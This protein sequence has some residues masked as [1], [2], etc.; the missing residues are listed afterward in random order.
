MKI[1]TSTVLELKPLLKKIP[2]TRQA[3]GQRHHLTT[4]LNLAIGAW[5]S[6][7]NRLTSIGEWARRSSPNRLKR[8]GCYFHKG[9]QRYIAPSEPTIRRVLQ[10]L[11]SSVLESI[12]ND[13]SRRLS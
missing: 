12:L 1:T 4:V 8:W 7:C 10:S 5:L 13:W 9:Q 6:G 3:R 11:A 2:D